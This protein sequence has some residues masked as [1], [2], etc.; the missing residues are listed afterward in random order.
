MDPGGRK[1]VTC[2]EKEVFYARTQTRNKC[3]ASGQTWNFSGLQYLVGKISRSNFYF[4]GIIP[5]LK[6]KKASSHLKMVGWFIGSGFHFLGPH[7]SGQNLPW[8]LRVN[9]FTPANIT[10]KNDLGLL[11]GNTD[12]VYRLQFS[13]LHLQKHPLKFAN[14]L[15]K[16]IARPSVVRSRPH[17]PGRCPFMF[18][19]QFMKEFLCSR[20][21]GEVWG[22]FPGAPHG[23]NHWSVAETDQQLR[24][25]LLSLPWGVV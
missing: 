25:T 19:Q 22:I 20:G 16:F 21:F 12:S 9:W 11:N 23:R 15:Q 13:G 18:H 6:Q 8:W 17:T 10:N 14:T 4:K 7:F 24:R 3:L 1:P 2:G 5:S